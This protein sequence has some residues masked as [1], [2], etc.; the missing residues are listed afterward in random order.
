MATAEYERLCGQNELRRLLDE[1]L[2]AMKAGSG[3]PAE[4]VFAE[5]ELLFENEKI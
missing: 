3:Q 4:K 1:G 5:M 2:A